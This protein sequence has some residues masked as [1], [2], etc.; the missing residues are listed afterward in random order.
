[1]GFSINDVADDGGRGRGRRHIAPQTVQN[2]LKEV[3]RD[4][5]QG[6][7]P[8]RPPVNVSRDSITTRS[9]LH[10]THR[11]GHSPKHNDH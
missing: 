1:M 3:N 9:L 7:Q 6:Q 8:R 10:S 2:S 11:P 5:R 4:H